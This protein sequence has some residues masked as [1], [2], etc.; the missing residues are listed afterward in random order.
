MKLLTIGMEYSGS[1]MGTGERSAD[2]FEAGVLERSRPSAVVRLRGH[3]SS[4]RVVHE[5][6][7]LVQSSSGE[8]VIVYYAGHGDRTARGECWCCSR[9]SVSQRTVARTINES[10]GTVVVFSDSCSSEH[11][12]NASVVDVD[13]VS[14]GAC[15]DSEDALMTG[16]GGL[17]TLSLVNGIRVS[18]T[19]GELWSFLMDAGVT[20]EH[21]SLRHSSEELLELRFLE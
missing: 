7:S 5:V 21:F 13:Y 19:I 12:V 20:A 18:N 1:L 8:T 6:R 3:V 16:D 17:F 11:I 4:T 15:L 14:I 10:T 2:A 9:G